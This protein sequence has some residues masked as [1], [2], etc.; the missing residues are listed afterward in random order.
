MF[1]KYNLLSVSVAAALISSFSPLAISSESQNTE[2]KSKSNKTLA[3][4]NVIGRSENQSQINASNSAVGIEDIE[5]TRALTINEA[6]RKVP[7]IVVRDEEGFGLRPNIGIRGQNPTRSVKALL[8]EDGIPASYAPYGD[9]AS[10]Y[11]APIQRY[12]RIEVLK[13]VEMLRFGPQSVS[14]TINYMTPETSES[15]EASIETIAGT[16]DFSSARAHFSN[17]GLRADLSH[18]QGDGARDNTHLSQTDAFAKYQAQINEQNAVT[19]RVN[20]MQEDSQV[21][22]TGI[23]DAEYANFGRSYNP[24]END[25]FDIKH[26]AA[27]ATHR[28]M[29]S[30][31][32]TLITSLYYT[33][34]N[35]D[36]WRQASTTTDTQCGNAFRDARFAGSVV[37]PNSCNSAQGR[38]R[39]YTTRGFEPRWTH[40]ANWLNADAELEIGARVH[41]ETQARQQLNAASANG[42]SGTLVENNYREVDAT[43]AFIMQKMAWN[44]FSITGAVRHEDV[45]YTRRNYLN[46]RA[47]TSDLNET[48][49]GFGVAY[50]ISSMWQVFANTHEGF[51]PP[52]TEDLINNNGVAIEVDAEQ[53]RNTELGLRGQNDYAKYNATVF[54]NDFSNQ[55]L[56]GSIA[57]GSTPVAQG[58]A[59]YQGLELQL[60]LNHMAL[61]N[62]DKD[63]FA[64]IAYTQLFDANQKSTFIAA[65][66]NVAVAGTQKGNRL[67]YA[68]KQNI[69]LQTGFAH[70]AWDASLE[71]TYTG[72]QF[73]DFAN[74][75]TINPFGNGQFGRID[76]HTLVGLTVNYWPSRQ[77]WNAFVAVKNMTDREYIVDRT[78]GILF[79]NPRQVVF[80]WNYRW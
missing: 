66:T 50:R 19:L 49:A 28:W 2:N 3:T 21:S 4:V 55:V 32:D 78:R 48:I 14:G 18:K 1:Y 58:E 61:I 43:S 22:Y 72:K 27:S 13:G 74:T 70:G 40:H 60:K 69:N 53:S 39:D 30:T 52:R 15:I 67:P 59:L 77:N 24:F 65:E 76:A 62:R 42:R 12:D 64:N 47:G 41:R 10:Y 63:W 79:G 80:G 29:P 75:Q 16:R 23:T 45:D 20:Q 35:R 17:R 26:R 51:A 8:L 33:Q 71:F 37:A 44:K 11:H 5:A 73:S 38:L 46:N 25:H 7:G 56:V 9:N 36:W 34:F 6:L 54:R 68:P 57:G 31:E